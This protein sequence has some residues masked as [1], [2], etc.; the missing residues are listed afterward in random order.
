MN[1]SVYE[2]VS[3]TEAIRRLLNHQSMEGMIAIEG[4]QEYLVPI[5]GVDEVKGSIEFLIRTHAATQLGDHYLMRASL[6]DGVCIG[7]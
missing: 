5:W 6:S 3:C 7:A 4:L 2:T 1:S